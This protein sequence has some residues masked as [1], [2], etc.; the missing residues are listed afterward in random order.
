MADSNPQRRAESI[1]FLD[2]DPFAE[3]TRIMG[4]DPRDEAQAAPEPDVAGDLETEL[5]QELDVS[6]FDAAPA[7]PDWRAPRPSSRPRRRR[8]RRRSRTSR[9]ISISIWR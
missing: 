2:D 6:G 9:P 8:C 1:E 4:H 3:L 7:A 5:F